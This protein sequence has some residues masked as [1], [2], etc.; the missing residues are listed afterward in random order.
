MNQVQVFAN[1][2][3]VFWMAF[4]CAVTTLVTFAIAIMTPPL[5]G[6]FCKAG[7]FQYPYLDIASRFPR[8]YYWMFPAMISNLFFVALMVGL[9]YRAEACRRVFSMFALII[10]SMSALVLIGDY[11]VQVSV[12][13]PSVL[14][15]ESDGVSLLTQFNP[16]GL[17][18][19]LEELGYLLMSLAMA[20]IAFA[21]SKASL[22]ERVVRWIFIGQAVLAIVLLVT[23]AGFMGHAREYVFEVAIISVAWLALIAGAGM[24]SVVL[25][26]DIPRKAERI[27]QRQ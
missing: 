14:A 10:S 19:A 7:C 18:I 3:F 12:I 5:S 15:K 21:L 17:F 2:R 4:A 27:Q 6:P 23:I 26:R 8:D 20:S 16:H 22:L 9:H 25:R 11:F 24:L 1:S 13:Q